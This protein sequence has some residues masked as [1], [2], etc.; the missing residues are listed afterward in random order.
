[1]AASHGLSA[2]FLPDT[3]AEARRRALRGLQAGAGLFHGMERRAPALFGSLYRSTTGQQIQAVSE[4]G[5]F[6][7]INLPT[8]RATLYPWATR[9][10]GGGY[11][12]ACKRLKGG[13]VWEQVSA[14]QM[15][16][17]A[18]DTQ[19]VSAGACFPAEEPDRI[20]CPSCTRRLP[21]GYGVPTR[22]LD[23]IVALAVAGKMDD[24][25]S[26]RPARRF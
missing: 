24:A 25:A 6:L 10:I 4:A 22:A 1:M 21:A 7:P 3:H 26:A 19:G 14:K 12:L 2:Q 5:R 9:K 13:Q 16:F 18:V 20:G 11:P 17:Q 23:T 8:G 15:P